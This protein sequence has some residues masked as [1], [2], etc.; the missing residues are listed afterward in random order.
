MTLK[1]K[2]L[3]NQGQLELLYQKLSDFGIYA[4]QKRILKVNSSGIK[5]HRGYVYIHGL[6]RLGCKPISRSLQSMTDYDMRSLEIRNST[7]KTDMRSWYLQFDSCTD[8]YDD[9]W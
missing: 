9:W 8:D 7:I 5:L 4:G 2:L 6:G 1:V 3:P